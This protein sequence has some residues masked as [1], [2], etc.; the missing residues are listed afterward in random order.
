MNPTKEEQI[1][2]FR[3]RFTKHI[4]DLDAKNHAADQIH[5]KLVQDCRELLATPPKGEL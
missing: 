2:I 5:A 1:K 4:W 3:A